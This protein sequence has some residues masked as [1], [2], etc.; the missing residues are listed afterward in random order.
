MGFVEP[1]GKGG[2][3]KTGELFSFI[4]LG[5]QKCYTV[6]QMIASKFLDVG[7]HISTCNYAAY[8]RMSN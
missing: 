1:K 4:F 7:D 2:D 6:L 8:K 3:K 5:I